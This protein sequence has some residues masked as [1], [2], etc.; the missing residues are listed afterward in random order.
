MAIDGPY[1]GPWVVS[2]EGVTGSVADVEQNSCVVYA[3]IS[4]FYNL[5]LDDG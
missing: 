4:G 1:T 2:I 5:S 3:A